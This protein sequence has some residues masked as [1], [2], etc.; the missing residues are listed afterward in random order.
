[1]RPPG[2]SWDRL[3]FGTG[4]AKTQH[5]DG[6]PQGGGDAPLPRWLKSDLFD[7][8][9]K[10]SDQPCDL[11]QLLGILRLNGLRKPSEALVIAHRG[12]VAWNDR[13]HRPYQR[14]QQ[15]WQ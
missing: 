8:N 5:A 12:H 13:R 7:D 1:G 4:P 3:I 14:G 10:P 11:V 2:E 6:A 15:V 9:R